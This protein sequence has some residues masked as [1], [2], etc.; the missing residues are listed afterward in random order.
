MVGC[1][2][3]IGRFFFFEENSKGKS[4]GVLPLMGSKKK[5]GVQE[6]KGRTRQNSTERIKEKKKNGES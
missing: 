3:K 2:R 5:G 4:D 6:T 1:G